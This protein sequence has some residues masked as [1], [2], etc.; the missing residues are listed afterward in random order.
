MKAVLHIPY[1]YGDPNEGFQYNDRDISLKEYTQMVLEDYN[2]HKDGI[3]STFAMSFG[4]NMARNNFTKEKYKYKQ[5]DYY[6]DD[7]EVNLYDKNKN[8]IKIDELISYFQTEKPFI[9]IINM[10]KIGQNEDLE[11]DIKNWAGESIKINKS[12][13]LT[14]IE[15]LKGLSK[16]D[17]KITF[18]NEKSNAILKNCKM[19]D[20]I[21]NR[22]FAFLVEKIEFYVNS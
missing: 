14:K 22:T 19:I 8:D 5:Q 16:K 6:F 7:T 18:T 9:I 17:L 10:Y 2:E 13:K 20:Y 15:K 21:N 4:D 11:T 1:S 12:N 3:L